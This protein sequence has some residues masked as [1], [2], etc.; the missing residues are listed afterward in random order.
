[1]TTVRD[2]QSG[3]NDIFAYSD[4][5]E[6]G[7]ILGPRLYST[8]PGVF[9]QGAPDT[10][11]GMFDYIKRY[12]D[13]YQT[14]LLKEYQT[15]DRKVRQWVAMACREFG[16]TA[17]TEGGGDAKLQLSQMA[18]G[19]SGN[20]HNLPMQPL[21]N[22]VVQYVVK[23][24]TFYTPTLLVNYGAPLA[25]E[26]YF[27]NSNVQSDRKL[28]RFIPDEVLDPM[29]TR[30]NAWLSVEQYAFKG[31][32]KGAADIVRAGGRVG[33]GGHGEL[34]GLGT[35]WE[36]WS[37]QSGGMTRLEALRCA[38]LF[39]A[40]A[41]GLQRDLGS[42][43]VGKLADLVVLDKDPTKEIRN[44]TSIKYVM[45]NGELFVG[46]TLDQIWPVEKKL[47]KMYWWNAN[48]PSRSN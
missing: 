13:A 22:D 6:T 11:E 30:R 2:P 46:D 23:T 10:K 14:N 40:E 5:V 42:I 24:S 32:A 34:Q 37:L 15:G 36:I 4:L 45:K 33:V 27:Q 48:P 31:F 19:F 21:Y 18:D 12:K 1:V 16:L 9:V 29:V 17:T 44:T 7:E 47:G 8:G 43:E 20:E 28:R 38:T 41:L 25:E 35:H 26:Y 39:G 3:T